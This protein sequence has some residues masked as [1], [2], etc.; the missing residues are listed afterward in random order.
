MKQMD[1]VV[2]SLKSEKGGES[3]KNELMNEMNQDR[4]LGCKEENRDKA[5][6]TRLKLKL[7]S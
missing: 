7:H 3:I 6:E 2:E 4:E 1:H 5:L